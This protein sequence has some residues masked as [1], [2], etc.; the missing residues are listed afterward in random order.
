MKPEMTSRE[1]IEAAVRLQKTD[2]TPC[3]LGLSY[4]AARYNR[5]PVADIINDPALFLEL[6][7]KTFEEL[8]GSDMVN[9]APPC[10]GNSPERFGNM[11]VKA[12]HYPAV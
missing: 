12:G 7:L 8:G 3:V 2:R 1:R 9:L 5:V 11:P 4:F 10:L 6:K